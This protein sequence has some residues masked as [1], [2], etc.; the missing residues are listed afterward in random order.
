MGIRPYDVT[1]PIWI[2]ADLTGDSCT[3]MIV[4]DLFNHGERTLSQ[5]Q[6]RE[7]GFCPNA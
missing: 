2:F 3:L 7:R 5:F 1:W 6:G 4:R